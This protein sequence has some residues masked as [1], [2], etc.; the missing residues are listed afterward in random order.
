VE[1][2]IDK[3]QSAKKNLCILFLHFLTAEKPPSSLAQGRVGTL[4]FFVADATDRDDGR[5][6]ALVNAAKFA[7]AYSRIAILAQQLNRAAQLFEIMELFFVLICADRMWCPWPSRQCLA[8]L[9]NSGE[10]LNFFDNT[11]KKMPWVW[12]G[13]VYLAI[14]VKSPIAL[15]APAIVICLTEYGDTNFR[16]GETAFYLSTSIKRETS[17]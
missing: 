15:A 2:D 9:R 1:T 6:R 4:T 10:C 14:P 5:S 13:F 8:S 17:T 7:A 11:D 16:C 3:T 12:V